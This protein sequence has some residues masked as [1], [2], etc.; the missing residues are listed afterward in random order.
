[1]TF[2]AQPLASRHARWSTPGYFLPP[3][4]FHEADAV[5]LK[6]Q[7]GSPKH[8]HDLQLSVRMCGSSG[9]PRPSLAGARPH[10]RVFVREPV[11]NGASGRNDGPVVQVRVLVYGPRRASPG[12]CRGGRPASRPSV[13]PS[14]FSTRS[15]RH[16]Q[17]HLSWCSA[18]L[19]P[20]LSATRVRD[21][22]SSPRVTLSEGLSRI[23]PVAREPAAQPSPRQVC[24][25]A[26]YRPLSFIF[27]SP[28]SS[29]TRRGN[30][31]PG[32]RLLAR[33]RADTQPLAAVC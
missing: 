3:G 25:G 28:K 5:A 23:F 1:M 33:F 8:F 29:W 6:A 26:S 22:P 14:V 18:A 30:P 9:P 16:T 2:S 21:T 31:V 7:V 20:S 32:Q 13:A 4:R 12:R 24:R 17:R 27:G 19:P 15:A 10:M 11:A